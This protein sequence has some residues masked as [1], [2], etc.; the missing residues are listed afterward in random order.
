[1]ESA[2][3]NTQNKNPDYTKQDSLLLICKI[4]EWLISKN[5]YS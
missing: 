1:M 2:F 3:M 5:N 4:L